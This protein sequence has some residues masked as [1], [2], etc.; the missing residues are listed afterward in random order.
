MEYSLLPLNHGPQNK[1]SGS[2]PGAHLPMRLHVAVKECLPCARATGIMQPLARHRASGPYSAVLTAKTRTGGMPTRNFPTLTWRAT[3][4]VSCTCGRHAA[5]THSTTL[6]RV[7]EWLRDG[8]RVARWADGSTGRA[9]VARQ[10]TVMWSSPPHGIAVC[11]TMGW[12]GIHCDWDTAISRRPAVHALRPRTSTHCLS[13]QIRRGC[14]ATAWVC[15]GA[16]TAG[17][18]RVLSISPYAPR[19]PGVLM[20]PTPP[21]S[22]ASTH[23]LP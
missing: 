22:Q 14:H 19:V 2:T 1:M 12:I 4:A 18:L 8:S 23:P 9:R 10:A 16:L 15:G 11:W 5:Q 20:D 17:I 3:A 13:A 7:Q 6:A 21:R